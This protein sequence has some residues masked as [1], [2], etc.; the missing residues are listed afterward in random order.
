ME[1]KQP[2]GMR[3]HWIL[4]ELDAE[5]LFMST[6]AGA[7]QGR[8][9]DDLYDLR[10]G[11]VLK[12]KRTLSADKTVVATLEEK[13]GGGVLS[14]GDRQ[15]VWKLENVFGTRWVLTDKEGKLVFSFIFKQG[16]AK[17]ARVETGDGF[18]EDAGPLLL[19]CWYVTVL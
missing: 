14:Y 19:L 9:G 10:D 16:L 17:I 2:E 6:P 11:G 7:A 3:R 8:V 4:E 5:L 1:W 12:K 15:Y 13:G 18:G